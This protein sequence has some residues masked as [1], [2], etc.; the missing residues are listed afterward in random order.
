MPHRAVLSR[1][2]A[3]ACLALAAVLTG[4]STGAGNAPADAAPTSPAAP[5][6]TPSPTPTVPASVQCL[7]GGTWV[8]DNDRDAQ[9]FAEGL[10]TAATDVAA[11]RAG[12]ATWV[13]ADGVLTRTF[14]AWQR[15]F[16]AVLVA[17][18]GSPQVTETQTLDG[19]TTATYE[20]TATDVVTQ[21]A[22]VAGLTITVAATRNGAPVE[23]DDSGSNAREGEQRAGS[24]GFTCDGETLLLA[25]RNEDGTLAQTSGTTLLRRR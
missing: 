9:L 15:T 20:A 2:P 7:E 24:W 4:C 25:E 23:F 16:S 14:T 1:R 10:G 3:A 19:T 18:P 6:P 11:S 22:D 12:E 8:V 21:A 13:F 17:A 5:T